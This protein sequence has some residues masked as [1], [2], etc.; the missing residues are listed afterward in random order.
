VLTRYSAGIPGLD[1]ARVW[2]D[3]ILPR[4]CRLDLNGQKKMEEILIKHG[5]VFTKHN[6]KYYGGY[7]ERETP[8][9]DLECGMVLAVVHHLEIA[10][11]G[12]VQ[13][14]CAQEFTKR[15][16]LNNRNANKISIAPHAELT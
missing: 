10:I 16:N 4:R 5:S 8:W 1:D 13:L 7:Q 14:N 2:P 3:E 9:M 12:L 11:A 15:R 6:A